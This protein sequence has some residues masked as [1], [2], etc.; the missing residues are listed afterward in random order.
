MGTRRW[1]AAEGEDDDEGGGEDEDEDEDEG[2]RR[3]EESQR[4][5]VETWGRESRRPCDS[6]RKKCQKI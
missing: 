2:R 4:R 1:P 5:G 3:R 6:V